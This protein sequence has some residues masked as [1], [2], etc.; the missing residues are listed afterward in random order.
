MATHLKRRIAQGRHRRHRPQGPPDGRGHPRRRDEARRRGGARAVA[1][2]STSGR[3]ELPSAPT[4]SPPSWRRSPAHDRRHQVR[5]GAD[6]Q[7][8][9]APARRAA[10][11][12]GRDAARRHARPQEHPGRQRRLLRA[13]RALSDGRLGAHEHRDRARRGRAPHHRLHAAEPGRAAPRDDRRDACSAAPTRSTCWAA[14][15]RSRRWRSAPRPSQPVDMLVGPGNAYVAEAKRQL[16]GRVGIDLFAGP[17][18]ILVDRRRHRRRRDGRHRSAGPGRARPD[19]SRDAASRPRA[20]LA[21]A[22]PARDRAPAEGAADRRRRRRGV[23]RLRRD[24]PRGHRSRK[25]C[26]RPTASPPSTSRC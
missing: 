10:R 12:R 13:G 6:P 7:F 24:H 25:P 4:T 22:L 18:E 8:R 3:R 20:K 5:A 9:P 14:C 26:A 17:T 16:F 21:E 23:A 1:R 11:R 19:Q 15:R 2:S